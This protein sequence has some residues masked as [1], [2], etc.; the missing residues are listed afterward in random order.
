MSIFILLV[1]AGK[2]KCLMHVTNIDKTPPEKMDL[3]VY[4]EENR[5]SFGDVSANLDVL[6][7][8][9][10]ERLRFLILSRM[11]SDILSIR[12]S[13]VASESTFSAGGRVIDDR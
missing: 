2:E 13:I 4:L 8:W 3:D 5:Y 6:A 10:S 11:T 12:V 1:P 7:W 9:K